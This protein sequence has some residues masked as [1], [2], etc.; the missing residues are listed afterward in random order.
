MRRKGP[1]GKRR[2]HKWT[3]MEEEE[4]EIVH[5]WI[6]MDKVQVDHRGEKR[7]E[8]LLSKVKA[9]A[10]QKRKAFPL[11]KALLCCLLPLGPFHD[12]TY[13]AESRGRR[14]LHRRRRS[15]KRTCHSG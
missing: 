14:G 5:K 15:L 7:D 11:F 4:G 13:Q 2:K 6:M 9:A 1:K 3:L 10:K 8:I 12:C